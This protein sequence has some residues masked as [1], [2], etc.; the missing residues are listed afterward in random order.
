VKFNL[1]GHR[2][3]NYV[4]RRRAERT[5]GSGLAIAAGRFD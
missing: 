2:R 5:M 3:N 1:R 4:Q